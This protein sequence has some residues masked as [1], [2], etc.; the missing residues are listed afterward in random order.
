[1]MKLKMLNATNRGQILPGLLLTFPFLLLIA[2]AYLSLSTTSLHLARQYQFHTQ[3]QLATDAG[4]D[5]AIA[6]INQDDSW[7]GTTGQ[8]ELH[9]DSSIKTTYDASV[10]NVDSD[11]KTLTVTG[12]TFW[13]ANAAA[14]RSSVTVKVDLRPVT[15]GGFSL[16]SGQGGLFM[17]NSS[18]IVGGDVFVNGIIN[19]Q[20]SAQIGLS[21]NPL[22]VQ[23]AHQVCPV[24]A[25]ATYPRICGSG[26]AG[27][28]IQILNSALIYGSVRANNQVSGSG[29][30]NPG[31]VASSGVEIQALPT[32]D[33]VAHKAAVATTITG[34]SASC[35]S[36]T[37]SWSANT[38]ITGDVTISNTCKVTVAG[39]IWITGDLEV[40][41]SGQL[42]VADSLGATRPIIMVD[43]SDGAKFSNSAELLANVAG[44][45]FEIITFWSTASC[46]PD[47][48]NVTGV[49]LYNSRNVPTIVLSNSTQGPKVIFYA[50]W[51][52]VEIQNSG[53]IGALIGQSIE[54]KNNGT[55]TFTTSA[56]G[57]N[58]F[59]V[60][61]GYRRSF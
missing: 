47:C 55:L 46:S 60:P 11:T 28:P 52:R 3:A 29:M 7:A 53:Q 33:R 48:A 19:L 8:S 37:K 35:S 21:T 57:G 50:Y 36:G 10:V 56:G 58:T 43:G 24:P 12:R 22:S 30:S 25:D 27:Q 26:E 13:P 14:A 44:A 31:L 4:I 16:I 17:S 18:K 42:I 59:W 41:N 9:N 39:N 6:Q 54:L 23:V 20:N 51:S 32:Y 2:A 38:K 40:K 45:G 49:D 15:S 34:S 5:F 61:N 1:M